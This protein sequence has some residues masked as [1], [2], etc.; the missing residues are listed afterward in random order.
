MVIMIKQYMLI[1]ERRC[2]IVT[3]LRCGEIKRLLK[4]PFLDNYALS[5]SRT[6]YTCEFLNMK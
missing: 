1:Y 4:P 6:T 5:D 3:D 2:S